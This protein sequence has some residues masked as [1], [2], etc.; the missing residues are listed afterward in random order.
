MDDYYREVLD[1][2]LDEKLL[3]EVTLIAR[4]F[5]TEQLALL[6]Q[7]IL[8]CAINCSRKE[9]F[10]EIM[11]NLDLD[12]QHGIKTA[13]QQ[14]DTFDDINSLSAVDSPSVA[15]ELSPTNDMKEST[16]QK[17]AELEAIIKKVNNEKISLQ[18]ENEKLS[19]K[20]KVLQSYEPN[21]SQRD[22]F[23]SEAVFQRL[24]NQIIGLQN[25][26]SKTEE[27]KEDYRLNAE[28]REKEVIKLRQQLEQLMTKLNDMKQDRDE[29]DRLRYLNEE[30]QRYINKEEVHKK[31]I[32][33]LKE[34]KR[35]MQSIE[36]RN[37]SLT[38]RICELEEETKR[39]SGFKAQIDVYKKQK[40]DL[41]LK[42]GEEGYRADRAEEETNRLNKK[43]EELIQ[44]RDKYV[45]E[46]NNLRLELSQFKGNNA[47]SFEA[48]YSPSIQRNERLVESLQKSD[49]DSTQLKE[50]FI[51]LE[52]ENSKL[53]E[54]LMES[55]DQ[56]VRLL[57]SQLEDERVRVIDLENENRLIKQKII[58]LEA[59]LKDSNPVLSDDEQMQT[60]QDI[61][62]QKEVSL[63]TTK[64]ELIDAQQV[65]TTLKN[66]IAKKDEE[67]NEK[68]DKYKNYVSKAKVALEGL[69]QPS[70]VSNSSIGSASDDINYWKQLVQQKDLEINKLRT[71]FEESNSFREM[72]A[73]LMTISFHNLVRILIDCKRL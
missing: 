22:S 14:M 67:L 58:K 72:E 62:K 28:L 1:K 34:T 3:P 44:E 41:R 55:D 71:D 51:R 6:L 15:P 64:Q 53:K 24:N 33:E 19:E 11:T 49:S 50:K 2:Q 9:H 38:K 68:E 39:L 57:E 45:N 35:Q 56:R 4:D 5:N 26:L 69:S 47:M 43:L 31:K 46:M 27:I 25:E 37:L 73:R 29:L 48:E 60:F 20:I 70:I 42:V 40:E 54:K 7:L 21:N 23:D 63:E 32:E 8:G 59:E 10:I 52:F 30:V 16:L 18:I 61:I 65:I 36:E 66:I 12:V 13:I 17:I